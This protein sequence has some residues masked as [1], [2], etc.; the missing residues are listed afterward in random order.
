M[1]SA[2]LA[3]ALI[4]RRI[5]TALTADVRELS[6]PLTLFGFIGAGSVIAGSLVLAGAIPFP[7]WAGVTSIL[8]GAGYLYAV[9]RLARARRARRH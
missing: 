7:V 1:R 3:D 8:G 6:T 2:D 9:W 4:M 5:T